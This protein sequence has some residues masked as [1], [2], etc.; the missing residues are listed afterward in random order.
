M[1]KPL[2]LE[3]LLPGEV[4]KHSS[5]FAPFPLFESFGFIWRVIHQSTSN[6]FQRS[7][8]VCV[9]SCVS[10]RRLEDLKQKKKRKD[11]QERAAVETTLRTIWRTWRRPMSFSIRC[12]STESR[13]FILESSVRTMGFPAHTACTPKCF[14]TVTKL[15]EIQEILATVSVPQCYP[16]RK[17]SKP[18]EH[19]G[20]SQN[21]TSIS[22]RIA[23]AVW[24]TIV[25]CAV[26]RRRVW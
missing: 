10:Q 15:Q 24:G 22:G 16:Q 4:S 20:M 23:Q 2:D 13:V 7:N 12:H 21:V 25:C 1:L 8:D 26:G 17:H 5:L 19:H 3:H 14:Y 18:F 11:L 9:W 6:V